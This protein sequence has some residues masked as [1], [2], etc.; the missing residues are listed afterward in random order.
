MCGKMGEII[1]NLQITKII[2]TTL[3]V[4]KVSDIQLKGLA[5]ASLAI[6]KPIAIT[7]LY[8]CLMSQN[9]EAA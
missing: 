3:F 9:L 5:E 6:L 1:D 4:K 2:L 7:L 8:F